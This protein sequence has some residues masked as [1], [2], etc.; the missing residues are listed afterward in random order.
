LSA[1]DERKRYGLHDNSL[2]N[3][4]YLK[5][6]SQVVDVLTQISR[7]GTSVL[8]FGCGENAVLCQLLDDLGIDC[9][10]YDPLYGRL[11]AGSNFDI[12]VLC[13]VIEHIREVGAELELIRGL[14]RDSGAIVLRTQIY[15]NPAS[16]PG[17]WYAQDP[18][19]IN[20]FNPRSLQRLSA[21]LGARLS[22]T[23]HP[24][25]FILR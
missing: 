14:L 24:D 18:T 22:P 4:G 11:L 21:T 16:F 15:D 9:R 10:A 2:S 23:A 8:D 3:G 12:I 20:F 5:F 19:H 17:W 6:L 1:D 7:P 13:E 25:I